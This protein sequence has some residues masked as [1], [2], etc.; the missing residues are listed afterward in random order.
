[1]FE[2]SST[3]SPFTWN[4]SIHQSTKSV[5]IQ[6]SCHQ[7]S[8]CI[9]RSHPLSPF[10]KKDTSTS[11]HHQWK[12][13]VNLCK[14]HP[15]SPSPH[16]DFSS[17][18]VAPGLH[19][20]SEAAGRLGSVRPRLSRRP[21]ALWKSAGV[22]LR[23]PPRVVA[24]VAAVVFHSDLPW[25]KMMFHHVKWEDHEDITDITQLIS[26]GY[27]NFIQESWEVLAVNGQESSTN[28]GN[29]PLPCLITRGWQ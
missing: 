18:S 24:V 14:S 8:K 1:M 27:P 20:L 25:L 15:L 11:I 16:P 19:D 12:S 26:G 5:F 3:S 23:G 21:S 10:I 13:I 9:S 4:P 28:D 17:F 22:A 7:P 29:F 6:F 2:I